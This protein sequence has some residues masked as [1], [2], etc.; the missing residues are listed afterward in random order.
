MATALISGVGFATD[1]LA[2]TARSR[3]LGCALIVALVLG[4]AAC[5]DPAPTASGSHLRT[6]VWSDQ[7]L[8]NAA[9]AVPPVTGA[10]EGDPADPDLVWLRGTTN[11]RLSIAWPAGFAVRFEPEAALYDERGV[12]V[13]RAG[14][15]V[16][17]GQ[18]FVGAHAGTPEDPYL[19]AGIV[20][21]GCYPSYQ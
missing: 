19:T 18:V 7:V 9:A 14:D 17:L 16:K 2:A 12:V 4:V 20:F 10:L 8:C 11:Q 15:I 3:V 21:E 13:A 1:R 5:A 6:F